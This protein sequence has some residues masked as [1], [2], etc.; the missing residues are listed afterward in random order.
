MNQGTHWYNFNRINFYIALYNTYIFYVDISVNYYVDAKNWSIIS[1]YL[2]YVNIYYFYYSSL[3]KI[4]LI[5]QISL[6]T[7]VLVFSKKNRRVKYNIKSKHVIQRRIAYRRCR[8][9]IYIK[10]WCSLSQEF[11]LID[12]DCYNLEC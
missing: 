1:F 3:N 10:M 11:S 2:C 4:F 8:Y 9:I 12:A 7:I 6:K 5:V